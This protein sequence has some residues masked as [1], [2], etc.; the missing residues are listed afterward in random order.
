M[1]SHYMVLKTWNR[2]IYHLL[3]FLKGRK[4][5]W[6]AAVIKPLRV[7]INTHIEWVDPLA[8]CTYAKVLSFFVSRFFL[9]F[10]FF[11]FNFSRSFP[12]LHLGFG[13]F[14]LLLATLPSEF[15]QWETRQRSLIQ[16]KIDESGRLARSKSSF[17]YQLVKNEK[18]KLQ[19]N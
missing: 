17:L 7:K 6:T 11:L 9:P 15:T 16:M 13:L 12:R 8:L 3:L 14:F 10:L 19:K 2:G 18:N 5:C 4:H 1:L